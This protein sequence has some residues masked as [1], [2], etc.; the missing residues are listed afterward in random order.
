MFL[1]D[2]GPLAAPAAT[3]M[4]SA[5][6]TLPPQVRSWPWPLLE[7]LAAFF[8][9]VFIV[10][11]LVASTAARSGRDRA[12]IDRIEQY[13]PQHAPT[14]TGD[15]HE[16]TGK[17][18]RAALK[19]VKRLMSTSVQ[20]RLADRLDL[21]GISRTPAEW[22]LLG[23]VLAVV[24]AAVLGL[25]TDYVALGALAGALI[26]WLAMRAGL[27]FLIARRRAAFS[28]QLPDLLQLLASAL[29]SG[30]SLPQALD[31]VVREDAQPASGEFSRAVS[32]AR[33]GGDLEDGLET[34]AGRMQSDDLRWTVMAIR[35]QRDIGG[36]MAEVL[37]TIAETI[38]ERAYLRRQVHSLSAEGRLSGY[39]LVALPILI[40]IWLFATSRAYMRPLYTTPAGDFML[41]VATVLLILGTLWMRKMIK[42]E[43]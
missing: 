5:A 12:L 3:A 22:A 27:S 42:V 20:Q 9:A 11:L 30:F 29:Q 38:R 32:E 26:G 19:T 18:G 15:E 8:A 4:H 1:P 13:G 39:I 37:L 40:G 21:A 16:D 28:E 10:V 6:L 33:L 2:A 24:I 14:A 36:N 17:V 34:I 23:C 7:G 35:I 25:S 31:A 43:V 41:L